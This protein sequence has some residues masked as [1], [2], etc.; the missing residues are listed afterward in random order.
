MKVKGPEVTNGDSAKKVKK[1]KK[2][3]KKSMK[4]KKEEK[5]AFEEEEVPLTRY[6]EESED[7]DREE[8]G[9]EDGKGGK[10]KV[11]HHSSLNFIFI[12]V[13]DAQNFKIVLC[14]PVVQLHWSENLTLPLDI[15]MLISLKIVCAF[16][17]TTNLL[18]GLDQQATRANPGEPRDRPPRPP[19]HGRPARPHAALSPRVKGGSL[20]YIEVQ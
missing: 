5:S 10:K 12:T 15:K 4:K 16:N 20:I 14:S 6:E 8:D 19:P 3:P 2:S 7:S 11:R 18:S 17:P 1:N 13:Y 9:G